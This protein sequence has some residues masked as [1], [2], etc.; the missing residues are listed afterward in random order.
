M[1][2]ALLGTLSDLRAQLAYLYQTD[3]KVIIRALLGDRQIRAELSPLDSDTTRIVVVAQKDA[4]VD[5]ALSSR[6]VEIVEG[7]LP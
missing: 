1:R 5:R 6:I 3:D 2:E 7:N 4:A